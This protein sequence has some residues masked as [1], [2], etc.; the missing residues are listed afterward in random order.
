M[1][2]WCWRNSDL[3]LIIAVLLFLATVFGMF[4]AIGTRL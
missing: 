2:E 1:V 3:L 4:E